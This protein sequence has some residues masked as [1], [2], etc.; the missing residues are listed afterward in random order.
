M[1]QKTRC[2]YTHSSTIC[3]N[4]QRLVSICS[5]ILVGAEV[6][7]TSPPI[8]ISMGFAMCQSKIIALLLIPSNSPFAIKKARSEP[9]LCME[10]RLDHTTPMPSSTPMTSR[11]CAALSSKRAFSPAFRSSSIIRSMPPLPRMTGTPR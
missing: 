11:T 8:Q 10:N 6:R 2:K 7:Q 3:I 5:W 9:Y 4:N 1:V